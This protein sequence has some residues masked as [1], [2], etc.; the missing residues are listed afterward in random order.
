[1]KHNPMVAFSVA[2]WRRYGRNPIANAVFAALAIILTI[3]LIPHASALLFIAPVTPVTRRQLK[4][5]LKELKDMQT[6]M[7]G[8]EVSPEDA[9]KFETL[10]KEAKDIQDEAERDDQV[11][12]V[13]RFAN[14]VPHTSLP[15]SP[16]DLEES[17]EDKS[18]NI[19]EFKSRIAGYIT[20][21]QL[22]AE[23]TVL[24]AYVKS[25]MP[26]GPSPSK[27]D[28]PG[29]LKVRGVPGL[30]HGVVPLTVEQRKAV[31][32]RL[33]LVSEKSYPVKSSPVLGTHVI[34]PDRLADMV[35]VDL[36]EKLGLR[37]ILNVSSTTSNL[38]QW[39]RRVS[40]TRAAAVVSEGAAKP[41][42]ATEYDL[43][44]TAVKVIAAWIPV[45][46]QQLQDAPQI[47]NIVNTDLLWD[48]KKKEEEQCMWGTAATATQFE[49]IAV[50]SAVVAGR[51]ETGDTI[52][53]KIR[54]AITDVRLESYEPNGIAMHPIDWE[55]VQLTKGSDLH[56]IYVV[57]TDSST[58][59]S[60]VWGVNVVELL[61]CE[62]PADT[63]RV[64]VVG[65][66]LRGATL[67]D[68]MTATIA[69][70]WQDDQFIK[71]MRTIRAEERI[72]FAVRRPKA[73]KKIVTSS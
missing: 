8:K 62:K 5:V 40:F 6:A 15:S 68:R 17:K 23:S 41:E 45:S 48:L 29:L 69:V 44:D 55:T 4:E 49:G 50:N 13:E 54:R 70:G 34:E 59:A 38:I 63:D 37:D 19:N 65:D 67:W 52:I 2:L 61:A 35:M 33:K 3:A 39:V 9:T 57:T 14:T 60:R 27:M 31:E 47:I 43:V 71:N 28:L 7:K 32:E 16:N 42:A 56:Y 58:G 72:A 26:Q 53:D 25:G 30:R 11:K 10:C 21:G 73:F 36:N 24:E 1:M 22:F 64:I 46:E 20:P 12:A 18:R 51:T 66:Y